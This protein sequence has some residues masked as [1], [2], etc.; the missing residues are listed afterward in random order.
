MTSWPG[1][2]SMGTVWDSS[3]VFAHSAARQ[4]VVYHCLDA[5]VSVLEWGAGRRTESLVHKKDP[6]GPLVRVPVALRPK[7][8][9]NSSGHSLLVQGPGLGRGQVRS[10]PGH[11]PY[12]TAQSYRSCSQLPPLAL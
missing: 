2:H 7:M 12:V 10:A 6:T 8:L 3:P 1:H 9:H 5:W 11:C 4:R